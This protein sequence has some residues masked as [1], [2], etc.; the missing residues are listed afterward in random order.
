MYP[1]PLFSF[2]FFFMLCLLAM[3]SVSGSWEPVVAA[4]FDDVPALRQ[5]KAG[6]P[7][8]KLTKQIL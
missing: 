2:L 1:G 6:L 3:S 7:N 5:H 8:S 4:I